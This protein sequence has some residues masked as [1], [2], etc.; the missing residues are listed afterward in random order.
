MYLKTRYTLSLELVPAQVRGIN[1]LSISQ[2]QL[3]ILNYRT[4]DVN[5]FICA[6][7]IYAVYP[8]Y[9]YV[10]ADLIRLYM[11]CY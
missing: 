3:K 7:Y 6:T 8:V 2:V 4:L 11:S 10:A 9:M 5:C 1:H